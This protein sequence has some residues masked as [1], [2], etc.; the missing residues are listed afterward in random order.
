MGNLLLVG[1]Q[2]V[3][4]SDYIVILITNDAAAAA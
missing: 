4:V 3:V 1:P 2:G